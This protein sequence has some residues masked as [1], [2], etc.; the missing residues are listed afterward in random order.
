MFSFPLDKGVARVEDDF[1][2]EDEDEERYDEEFYSDLA[3]EDELEN[4]G[5]DGG[6]AAFMHGYMGTEE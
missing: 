4:G 3:V 6:E 2:V 1:F 5:L